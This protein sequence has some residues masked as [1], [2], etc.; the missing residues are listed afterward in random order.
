MT[1]KR[2]QKVRCCYNRILEAADCNITFGRLCE[3][4]LDVLKVV[5][6]IT[7][8][9]IKFVDETGEEDFTTRWDIS[10]EF[11]KNP[12]FHVVISWNEY[13]IEIRK[14]LIQIIKDSKK[15]DYKC[16]TFYYTGLV[17]FNPFYWKES[18]VFLYRL[19]K[20]F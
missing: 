1:D 3:N 2:F 11:E 4:V 14:R 5:E 20:D 9:K 15:G 19:D 12:Q 7:R 8:G 16:E 18:P 13:R 17:D 6:P 10:K